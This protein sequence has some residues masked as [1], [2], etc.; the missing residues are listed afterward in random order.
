MAYGPLGLKPCEFEELQ[1]H[2][3]LKMLE[4][5]NWRKEH[6]E[7]ELAYFVCQ[8]MNIEGKALK[9][10]ITPAELLKPLRERGKPTDG[11]KADAEYLMK[12][13]KLE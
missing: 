12:K 5:Y 8:L 7:N 1:P 9:E 2:E 6:R 11:K 10:N 3:L 13:F 4:G